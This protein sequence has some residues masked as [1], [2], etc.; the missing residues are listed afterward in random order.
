MPDR[1]SGVEDREREREHRKVG[2]TKRK[3]GYLSS[4]NKGNLSRQELRKTDHIEGV[5]VEVNLK[6]PEGMNERTP[7]SSRWKSF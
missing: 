4:S 1:R 2:L 7:D 3:T 5:Y 6:R